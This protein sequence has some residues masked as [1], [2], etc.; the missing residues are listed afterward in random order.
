METKDGQAFD[1]VAAIII[2]FKPERQVAN[3]SKIAGDMTLDEAGFEVVTSVSIVYA[4]GT[5]LR[6]K[7]AAAVGRMISRLLKGTKGG[8]GRIIMAKLV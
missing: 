4:T 2:Y 1:S 8:E 5:D 6:G 7:L 3:K